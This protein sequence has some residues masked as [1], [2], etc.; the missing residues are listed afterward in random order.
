M[1]NKETKSS[2]FNDLEGHINRWNM[3]LSDYEYKFY[4]MT[5]K[6]NNMDMVLM[7]NFTE[8]DKL[9]KDLDGAKKS[10]KRLSD[11]LQYIENEQNNMN[12][13]LLQPIEKEVCENSTNL[14][15]LVDREDLNW[16]Q[17]RLEMFGMV[18][19]LNGELRDMNVEMS[20]I[21]TQLEDEGVNMKEVD[22]SNT[23]LNIEKI[24]NVQFDSLEWLMSHATDDENKLNELVNKMEN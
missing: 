6:L 3:E 8:L 19:R 21:Q 13:D 9:E 7:K 16:N 2:T 20:D 15:E 11:E 14:L 18:E 23:F 22:S 24:M 17:S 12:S 5:E 1:M 10:Q 4:R